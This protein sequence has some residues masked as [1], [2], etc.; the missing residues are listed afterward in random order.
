MTSPSKLEPRRCDNPSCDGAHR[1]A[2]AKPSL[3]YILN[4]GWQAG[5]A[6]TRY[7]WNC[8]KVWTEMLAVGRLSDP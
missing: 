8:F 4:P 1:T 2:G 5:D 6:D 3:Y 7:C